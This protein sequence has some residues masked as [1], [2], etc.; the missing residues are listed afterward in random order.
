MAERAARRRRSAEPEQIAGYRDLSRIGHGGF[1]VVYRA[2]SERLGRQVAVKVLAADLGEGRAAARFRREVQLAGRLSGHP[3]VVPVLDAGVARSGRPYLAMEH[4]TGGSVKSRLVDRGPLPVAEVAAIGCAVAQA[5]AAAHAAGILHQDIKPENILLSGSGRPALADFGIGR[6][7]DPGTG[8]SMR[9]HA[10]TVQHTAPEVIEG[11]RSSPASDV[12]SLGSTLY[13]LL[14]GRPPFQRDTDEGIAP[15]LL[16]VL[17]EEPSVRRPDVPPDLVAVLRR[18]MSK[19]PEDRYGSAAEFGEA[20]RV[21]AGLPEPAAGPAVAAVPSPTVV[22]TD[23]LAPVVPPHAGRHR[24]RWAAAGAVLLALTG[25]GVAA[26]VGHPA[27]ARPAVPAG[28]SSAGAL[29][30]DPGGPASGTS[31]PAVTARSATTQ[32]APRTAAPGT[33]TPTA[34]SFVPNAVR[35]AGPDFAGYCAAAGQGTVSRS[36][37]DA[38]GWR[39]SATPGTP[40]DADAACR[41]TNHVQHAMASVAS[42]WAG[43]IDCW[44]V[45][46]DLGSADFAG[47]CRSLGYP[48]AVLNR[49]YYAY[50]W[51]CRND[52]TPI[53]VDTGCQWQFGSRAITAIVA[54]F[55]D[56]DSWHC[57]G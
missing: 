25:T 1:S 5:L 23:R 20:L 53:R 51:G 37:Q 12:Y 6:L 30:A 17:N 19:R 56:P 3:Y 9:T 8:T 10:M 54:D 45:V 48:G 49:T 40:L 42:F 21:A 46:R 33:A 36:G 34:A 15:M 11:G 18:A 41:W 35:L 29:G 38:Y 55:Y 27:G 16:R 13:E 4:Y 24:W 22:R 57:W 2:H 7:T 50:G 31:T 39:C 44:D 26:A 28:A 32:P 47:Y 52:P 43:A 14:E